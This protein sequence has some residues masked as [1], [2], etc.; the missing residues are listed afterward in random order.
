[1]CELIPF[2]DLAHINPSVNGSLTSMDMDVSFI[3]MQDVSNSG[4]WIDKQTRK[5]SSVINGYTAFQEGDILFAKITPCMENGKGTHAIGLANGIGFGSTEF[6][7][8]RAKENAFPEF[9][10]HWCN[11]IEL[12]TAAEAQMTGS[13]GQKRVPTNFF[14]KFKIV[15]IGIYEQKA[16]AT[17]LDTLDITI[18]QAQA[19]IAK[20]K[21]V[22][23]GML[24]DLLTRGLDDNGELRDPVRHPEQFKDSPLGQIPKEWNPI[25]IGRIKDFITSG[26]RGWAQ[27]YQKDGPIF[28]RI[29]NL[30]REHINLNLD[31]LIHV[32]PPAGTEGART[33]VKTGDILISITADLGI[34]GYISE[35][36]GEAYVNQHIALVRLK[37]KINSRWVAHY[38]AS[39]TYQR[40]FSY[41][42]DSGAKAGMN[43]TSVENLL[44]PIP[45]SEKEQFQIDIMIDS[46]DDQI[47]KAELYFKKLTFLKQALMQDLLT[48]KVRVPEN[49]M[50]AMP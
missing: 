19:L 36:I 37:E 14:S 12:R 23:A 17:I 43:L 35:K 48:G 6:H 15:R 32:S 10:F 20:L 50:E 42:N 47:E 21:Q 40:H 24:Q 4:K 2:T 26:S 45:T 41:L 11:S 5:K 46:T 39:S 38:L 44:V 3:P 7:V 27:F 34:I 31:D 1:M 13:A 33:K 18:Q 30:T 25:P 16:I 9:I 49:M 8:L 28:I 22:K 29:G